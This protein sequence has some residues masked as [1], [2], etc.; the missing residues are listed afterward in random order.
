LR[1]ARIRW[2]H[3]YASTLRRFYQAHPRAD[4]PWQ[5]MEDRRLLRLYAQ[6]APHLHGVSLWIEIAMAL[7]RT[8]AAVQTRYGS[9]KAGMRL[10]PALTERKGRK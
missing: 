4:Q 3:G 10:K 7:G 8:T 6:L 2:E 5:L 9:L 1:E